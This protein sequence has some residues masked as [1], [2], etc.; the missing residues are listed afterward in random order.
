[1]KSDADQTAILTFIEN[2]YPSGRGVDTKTELVRSEVIDSY[3]I[4]QMIQFIEENFSISF[5]DEDIT[6]DNFRTVE[7]ISCCVHRIKAGE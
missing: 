3:G 6:P 7:A 1:M 4:V 5:P 2:N